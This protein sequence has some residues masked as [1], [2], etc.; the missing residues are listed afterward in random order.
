MPVRD[1]G[2]FGTVLPAGTRVSFA[3]SVRR[4]SEFL[5]PASAA[6]EVP[7]GLT[8]REAACK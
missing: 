2:E 1:R 8:C 6:F 4:A 7:S 3:F 5:A